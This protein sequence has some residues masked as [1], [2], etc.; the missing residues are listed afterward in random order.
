MFPTSYIFQYNIN[1][2]RAFSYTFSTDSFIVPIIIFGIIAIYSSIYFISPYIYSLFLEQKES[3]EKKAKQAVISNLI[4]MKEIQGEIEKE[5]EQSLLNI[6]FQE[7][8]V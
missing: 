7:K 1:N 5:I 4:L 6:T 3:Q 8:G 2:I